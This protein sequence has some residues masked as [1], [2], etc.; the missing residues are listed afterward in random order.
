M[1]SVMSARAVSA[2]F[3]DRN[4]I[5]FAG[6]VSVVRLAERCGLPELAAD[7]LPIPRRVHRL[8]PALGRCRERSPRSRHRRAGHR[9]PERRSAGASSLGCLRRQRCLAATGVPGLQPH[10]RRWHDRL[11]LPRQSHHRHHPRRPHRH[12]RPTGII[13]AP[14][15]LA[16]APPLAR[17]TRLAHT[18]R[19]RPRP[20]IGGLSTPPQRPDQD[21]Q[22]KS[23]ADQR[24]THA[25]IISRVPIP[26]PPPKSAHQNHFDGSGLSGSVMTRPSP[27]HPA[28]EI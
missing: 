10:P 5:G 28:R 9:R 3:D 22:W 6:L 1:K 14:T 25:L 18:V 7:L 15:D 21:R 23:W 8:A 12:P 4:L 19:Y 13:R 16:S 17:R 2:R 26:H 20:T 27:L 24:A 11:G